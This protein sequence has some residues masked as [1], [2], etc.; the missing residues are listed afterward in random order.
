MSQLDRLLRDADAPSPESRPE[1]PRGL[2]GVR[3]LVAQRYGEPL[4]LP[5]LAAAARMPTNTLTR[6]FHQVYGT[7]PMRW[8]WSF[9]TLLAAELIARHPGWSLTDV[10]VLCGFGSSAHFSRRFRALLK[11]SP[12]RY[13]AR[14]RVDREP[15]ERSGARAALGPSG[16]G[17][18]EA[19][20][21]ARVMARLS[22]LT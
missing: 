14:A 8:L 13:R 6:R 2:A 4:T 7:S 19:E 3:E 5:D 17:G 20:L 1:L 16:S 21:I 11:D 15:A 18:V 22:V 12:S 9:R 10:A